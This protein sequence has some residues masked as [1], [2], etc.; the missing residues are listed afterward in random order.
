MGRY[1]SGDIEGKFWF[2]LQAS[3]AAGRF[4]GEEREPQYIEYYFDE[5]HLEEVNEEID[6]IITILGDKKKIIDDFFEGKTAYKDEELEAIG[7]TKDTL[8]DYA[9]LELGIQIR[10]CIEGSGQCCFEAEL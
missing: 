9:D 10:D 4:G 1:Y 8:R 7:I 6:R 3:N 5:E 2:G